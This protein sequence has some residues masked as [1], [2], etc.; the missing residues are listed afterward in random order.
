MMMYRPGGMRQS[1]RMNTDFELRSTAFSAHCASARQVPQHRR[2]R[3]AQRWQ[4]VADDAP[5][6]F[7][8]NPPVFV[9]DKIAEGADVRPIDLRACRQQILWQVAHGFRNDLETALDA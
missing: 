9:P 8:I 4:L 5:D 6:D 1:G 3:R 2:D 7:G